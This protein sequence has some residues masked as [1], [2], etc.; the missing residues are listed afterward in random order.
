MFQTDGW[1][2]EL[3]VTGGGDDSTVGRLLRGAYDM[4]LHF[5]PEDRKS[6]V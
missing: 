2:Y 5:A 4:H 1:E 6:V 3:Q